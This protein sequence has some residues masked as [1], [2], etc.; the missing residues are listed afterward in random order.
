MNLVT[1]AAT[2]LFAGGVSCAAVQGSLLTGLITRQRDAAATA[3][4][5]R[6]SRPAPRPG[7][8]RSSASKA[9]A[10]TSRSTKGAKGTKVANRHSQ[11]KVRTVEPPKPVHQRVWLAVRAQKASLADDV[12]PV[13]AFLSGKLFSHTLLGLL[14]GLAGSAVSLSP[15]VRGWLQLAA[16][17][18]VVAFGLAQLKIGPFKNLVVEPP[19]A[20]SRFVRGQ[21][22]SQAAFAPAILGF[23]TILIPCG[24]TLSM[25]ALA[26][27]SGSPWQGAA[28]MAVFVLATSPLFAVLG[29][30]ARKAVTAWRGRLAVATGLIVLAMGVYTF[31]GGLTLLDS[32]FAAANLP[33]TLGLSAGPADASTVT[34]AAGTQEAVITAR[35][36]SYTPGN[37]ALTAGVPTTLVVHADNN[38][39]CTRAFVIRGKQYVLPENGDT[40]IDLGVLQPGTLRYRCGM[41]MYSGQ[42]T[43]TAAPPAPTSK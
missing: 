24:I 7:V 29:Y 13:G 15:T 34:L 26:L 12:T 37:I 28:I 42:L 16:G 32:P 33:Q 11:V 21:A 10:T 2:G 3:K 4:K 39:G 20:W 14:L 5:G 30:A 35:P 23:F 17:G 6:G 41:G 1:V 43:I 9:G 31:N 38:N 8:G 36:G 40:R 22:R 27:T 25:E 19:A 18:L